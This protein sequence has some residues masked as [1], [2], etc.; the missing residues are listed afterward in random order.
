[1]KAWLQVVRREWTE[2]R[3]LVA[4]AFLL[5]WFPWAAPW[6]PGTDHLKATEVR[7]A[8][9]ILVLVLVGLG[10]VG[11]LA[12][13]LLARD[14]A[15]RRLSFFLTRPL[16]SSTFWSA[17][18]FAV[19]S[20]LASILILVLLPTLAAEPSLI[21][22]LKPNP[23]KPAVPL[24]AI[25]EFFSLR[26]NPDLP[27]ALSLPLMIPMAVLA[28]LSALLLI[29]WLHVMV[30]SRSQWLLLDVVALALLGAGLWT[31]WDELI[32][33]QAYGAMVWIE[34]IWC[35]GLPLTLWFAGL[36]QLER[37]RI[38]AVRNHRVFSIHAWGGLT[39]LTLGTMLYSSWITAGSVA[40]LKTVMA[41]SPNPT[42]SHMVIAGTLKGRAGHQAAFVVPL[43]SGDDLT[44]YTAGSSVPALIQWKWSDDGSRAVWARCRRLV[45]TACELWTQDLAAGT[46]PRPTGIPIRSTFIR[47]AVSHGG[48]L[49]AVGHYDGFE[50]YAAASGELIAAAKTPEVLDL[51][52]I[53]PRQVRLLHFGKG[54]DISKQ[55]IRV[56][57]IDTRTSRVTGRIPGDVYGRFY[58]RSPNGSLF[59]FNS[60]IPRRLELRDALSGETRVDLSTVLDLGKE[61]VLA[62]V[63]FVSEH[64]LGVV[65]THRTRVSLADKS[66]NDFEILLLDLP[67]GDETQPTIVARVRIEQARDVQLGPQL[68]QDSLTVL[69]THG[70]PT[71][72]PP[73]PI[74]VEAGL[75]PLP[76]SSTY[77]LRPNEQRLEV[78]AHGYIPVSVHRRTSTYRSSPAKLF[79]AGHQ[80][81]FV[82]ED[83]KARV[84]F[85]GI[86]AP[87]SDT[88][89]AD[90]YLSFGF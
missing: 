27:K 43:G 23:G 64:R 53:S 1:M 21:T 57:D 82:L 45:P 54:G 56:F 39:I 49:I 76:S 81:L 19:V 9:A 18:V 17:R 36:R 78:V 38:D 59:L 48:Q 65:W 2:W 3:L 84:V 62:D 70:S 41:V 31:V 68:E 11:F 24:T 12:P 88:A 77:L 73:D 83:G 20:I 34:R 72:T 16:S 33:L 47:V 10:S 80:A 29:H 7:Q 55:V 58:A 71:Q 79:A 74:L 90:D 32:S 15:E 42:G 5:G 60:M 85:P 14:L 40:E 35:I 52:F 69:I 22:S 51:D 61:H 37:G 30:R 50:V 87:K 8:A 13:A 46:E 28:L 67:R 66:T 4:A 63:R 44:P 25:G 75:T 86:A 89:A 6:L 26:F